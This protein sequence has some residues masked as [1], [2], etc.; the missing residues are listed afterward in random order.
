MTDA[1]RS[2]FEILNPT[3]P[4][5]PPVGGGADASPE[6]RVERM[7]KGS[8]IF[9]FMKGSPDA[10]R[11]GFSANTVALLDA[12]GFEY[13]S[14]DVLSDDSIR[15]AAKEYGNWPTFPQVWL[16]GELLGGHDILLE[17]HH[18]GELEKMVREARR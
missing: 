8:E 14:F 6:E 13:D 17:M 15:A 10:P 2:P 3:V 5:S 7:V 12:Y 4:G 9:V 16:H 18:S 1:S 11:C